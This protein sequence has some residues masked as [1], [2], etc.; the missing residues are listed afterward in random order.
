MWNRG[1]TSTTSRIDSSLTRS[2][3]NLSGYNRIQQNKR[4]VSKNTRRKSKECCQS[5]QRHS[6]GI[7]SL[8][9]TNM[10]YTIRCFATQKIKWRASSAAGRRASEKERWRRRAS[11]DDLH[12]NIGRGSKQ[13]LKALLSSTIHSQRGG[14]SSSVNSSTMVQY[15]WAS[16]FSS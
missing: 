15:S 3:S 11:S 6:I 16:T 4:I 14:H 10:E 5:L 9:C 12:T 2:L 1:C 7:G 8:Q 13:K